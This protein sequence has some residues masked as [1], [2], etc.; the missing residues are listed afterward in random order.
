MDSSEWVAHLVA[1]G[2]GVQEGHVG[3]ECCHISRLDSGAGSHLC[4]AETSHLPHPQLLK[5]RAGLHARSLSSIDHTLNRG[6]VLSTLWMLI[7][8]HDRSPRITSM[9]QQA[10]H[11]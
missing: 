1:K 6:S 9:H 5:R 10:G 2:D 8:W 7:T 11:V 3:S 4:M